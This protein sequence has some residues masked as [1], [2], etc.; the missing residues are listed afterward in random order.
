MFY[1]KYLQNLK[2]NVKQ[3]T[4]YPVWY[5]PLRIKNKEIGEGQGYLTEKSITQWKSYLLTIPNA[6]YRELS[7]FVYLAVICRWIRQLIEPL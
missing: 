4:F 1:K 6:L 7:R 2:Y 3:A 5:F